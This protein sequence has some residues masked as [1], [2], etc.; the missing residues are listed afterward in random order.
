MGVGVVVVLSWWLKGQGQ[1]GQGQ[2]KKARKRRRNLYQDLLVALDRPAASVEG[3]IEETGW[4][5]RIRSG[6]PLPG[7]CGE[8]TTNRQSVCVLSFPS[9][10]RHPA[11]TLCINPVSVPIIILRPTAVQRWNIPVQ[12]LLCIL[13]GTY[14]STAV[15]KD[16][17]ATGTRYISK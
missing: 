4:W 7:A 12:K 3:G 16:N 11:H 10:H 9:T 15:D 1:Q 17:K 13:P 2:R 5:T 8:R 6:C 14:N